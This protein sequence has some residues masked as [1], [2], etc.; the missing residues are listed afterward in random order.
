MEAQR[1]ARGLRE[2]SADGGDA[3]PADPFNP[4]TFVK[5]NTEVHGEMVLHDPTANTA[6]AQEVVE[7]SVM[8]LTE[9]ESVSSSQHGH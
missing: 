7:S 6:N 3:P 8:T 2:V 1:H 9:K 4:I 5:P